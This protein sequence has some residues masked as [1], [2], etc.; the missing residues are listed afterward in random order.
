V[1]FHNDATIQLIS[2]NNPA[3]LA[4]DGVTLWLI[5]EAQ[6]LS[7]A[8][9]DNLF[10]STAER[11]GVIVAF[12]VSEGEGP[13]RDI[14]LRGDDKN[15][16]EYKRLAYP[17]AANPFVPK[18]RIDFAQRTLLPH[19]FKQLYLAQ[20]EGELGKIFRNVEGCVNSKTVLQAPEGYYYTEAYRPGHQYYVGIDLGRLSDWSV[21]T[22]W[23]RD[24]ELIA[25]DRFNIIDWELQK[26][27]FKLVLQC[28]SRE[29]NIDYSPS[30]C[31]DSTG[32]GDPINDDLVNLGVRVQEA[33]SITSNARKRMLMDEFAI[34]VG[35]G[36][37]SYPNIPVF[38]EE[39]THFEAK[40]SKKEGSNVVV[41]EAPSGK[42]DDF[43]LS[44]AFAARIIPRKAHHLPGDIIS[45]PDDPAFVRQ[46]GAWEAIS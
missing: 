13:F 43:V 5:D 6:Y 8:A 27:R 38:L 37:V 23:T 19:K 40:K 14:C 9:W 24:G 45:D 15:Y 29:R 16:P 20:W 18:W 11:N 36:D 4:G 31:I 39:L 44:A 46:V 7:Q 21:I 2:A 12:G 17:T 28:Y 34:R 26:A 3:A 35:S 10:P 42:H 1:T 25:W 30:V 22:I 33:F 41:Y 32:I